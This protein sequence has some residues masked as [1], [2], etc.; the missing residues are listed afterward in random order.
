VNLTFTLLFFE[1]PSKSVRILAIFLS[2]RFTQF[3]PN[4]TVHTHAPGRAS[5]FSIWFSS[6]LCK[7]LDMKRAGLAPPV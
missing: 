1:V 3:L 7:R 4:V 5:F 2:V 6:C